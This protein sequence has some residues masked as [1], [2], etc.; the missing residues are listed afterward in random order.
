VQP[1][2][3]NFVNSIAKAFAVLR[4]FDATLPELTITEVAERAGLDRGTSFR[5]VHTLCQLG[6]LASVPRS[7]RFRLTLKCLEIGY[8][9]LAQA[10]L[11][12]LARP[13][14]RELVPEVA[15]AASL[16]M[17][18][19]TDVVYI[20][21]V[22]GDLSRPNLNRRIGSRTGAYGAALGQAILAFLPPD[23]QQA[24][25]SRSNRVKLSEKTLTDIDALLRRLRHVRKQGYAVSDGENA[26]GLRTVA[27]PICDV[28]GAPVAGVSLTILAERTDLE[29]FRKVAV[30][31]LLVV[32]GE[33][34]RAVQ[35]TFGSIVEKRR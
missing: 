13:L 24:I 4:A 6:Y 19:D 22:E 2:P 14:L 9:P 33:L 30:P 25:L 31:R 18:D 20:E 27:A 11:K 10:D 28:D 34:A 3:K 35:L 1:D 8:T 26:Y 16:G 23:E 5:L 21:R 7:R 15:D 29:S 17:L 12:L 32:A